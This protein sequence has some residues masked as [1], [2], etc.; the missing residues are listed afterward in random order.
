MSC[1]FIQVRCKPGTAYQVADKIADREFHSSIFSTSGDF[2]LLMQVY[3]PEGEDI[4]R[5][6]NDKLLDIEFIE[7]TVTTLTFKAF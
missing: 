3:I 6:I 5:Y 4:G 1:V 2:D 7:R